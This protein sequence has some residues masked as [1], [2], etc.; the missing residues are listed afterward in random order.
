[1]PQMPTGSGPRIR[2]V[3]FVQVSPPSVVWKRATPGRGELVRFRLPAQP[4]SAEANPTARQID[5][6]PADMAMPEVEPEET[7]AREKA[8]KKLKSPR[9]P[10]APSRQPARADAVKEPEPVSTERAP[11]PTVDKSDRKR[12]RRVLV[13]GDPNRWR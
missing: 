12:R 11:S 10:A 1:M 13:F 6:V 3:T 9:T 7:I 4:T 5:L 8:P 2:S